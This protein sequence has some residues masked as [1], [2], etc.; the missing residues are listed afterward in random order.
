VLFIIFFRH[1]FVPYRNCRSA[2]GPRGLRDNI[3][4]YL[5]CIG[6]VRF[7]GAGACGDECLD[8]Y[9][10]L[11]GDR[12]Q[13][14]PLPGCDQHHALPGPAGTSSFNDSGVDELF[15]DLDEVL[16][17]AAAADKMDADALLITST[18]V[19]HH[20]VPTAARD[21]RFYCPAA[22]QFSA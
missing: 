16:D 15:D 21:S 17:E 14:L 11:P 20:D 8:A 9:L 5:Y 2:P 18:T 19:G 12:H 10:P 1:T 7:V 22:S 4:V 6:D 3:Y 13:S